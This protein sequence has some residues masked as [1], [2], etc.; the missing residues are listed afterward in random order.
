MPRSHV[1]LNLNA[2]QMHMGKF[3]PDFGQPHLPRCDLV[4]E[5]ATEL[6][7]PRGL[8]ALI[9][10]ALIVRYLSDQ[11]HRGEHRDTPCE[12]LANLAAFVRES[13]LP[14]LTSYMAA[15]AAV[16]I[17]KVLGD[18]ALAPAGGGHPVQRR[19]VFPL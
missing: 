8:L 6:F 13:E 7:K 4:A 12:T 15:L 16:Y 18:F 3:R 19:H 9:G 5:R 11:I 10:R 2:S 17:E 14:I 1:L